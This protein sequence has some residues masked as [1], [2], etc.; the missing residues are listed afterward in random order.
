MR[1]TRA[2]AAQPR[3][4]ASAVTL[5][6]GIEAETRVTSTE[7]KPDCPFPATLTITPPGP[8][9]LS[10]GVPIDMPFTALDKIVEAR[11]AGKTFPEDGSGS[12]DVTVKRATIGASGDRL[13]I[14]LLLNAKEKKS[15]FGLGG[16]AT[17]HIWGKPTL[18]QARQTLRLTDVELAVESEAALG[19][20]GTAARAAM[21]Y[22]Q[23]AL[24]DQII[25]LKPLASNA[26]KRI[27]TV[28]ADY[29]KN[30]EG[31]RVDGEITSLKLAGIAF[32]SKTL[33]VITEAEGS[34][35]VELTTFPG[36]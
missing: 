23:K 31:I 14:S 24:A 34:I 25:D 4:D 33:R 21:P 17:V 32:D 27:G 3:I 22:L 13:L 12:V 16:E 20:L 1:P 36:L 29:R 26:Q 10:I 7:T 8:G 2:V 6:L 19:L 28:I 9:K 5:T 15:L 35:N 18:D 30:E 11:F